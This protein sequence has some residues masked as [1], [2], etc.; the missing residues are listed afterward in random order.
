[1]S[2]ADEL[3]ASAASETNESA[4]T[5]NIVIGSDRFITVP[6]SLK[7]IA[8]Q[9]DHDVETVTF[10]CPRYWDEHDLSAMSVY[11][12]Y[13]RSDGT[14]GSHLCSNVAADAEDSSIMH[15]DWTISGHVTYV[16]GTLSF[17]VCIK[18]VGSDGVEITHWNSELN[19]DMYVSVGMKCQETVLRRYPDIITQL[20]Y[21]MDQ[22]EAIVS[23]AESAKEGAEA[24][25]KAI[26]NMTV[27]A[28]SVEMSEGAGVVKTVQNGVVNLH[29]ELPKGN[30]GNGISSIER[31]D[32]TG[33]AGTTDTYTIT[34]TDGT[35]TTFQVYNGANGIDAGEV[36]LKSTY[37][38]KSR[39]TDIF[40]YVDGEIA[41]LA[42][43][44]VDCGTF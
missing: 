36:L 33:A 15:F 21:R 34:F 2:Q 5:G 38:A 43:S 23:D 25:Q 13:M 29:F 30:T 7:K 31:T 14:M 41:I 32:G 10:D 39:N 8:V 42:A 17:L 16:A 18:E 11:V 22:S 37:D 40:D 27:S 19:T 28:E 24:A 4:T 35:T 1:M 9:Y 6:E 26:E 44:D 12:N 3:L 20:L